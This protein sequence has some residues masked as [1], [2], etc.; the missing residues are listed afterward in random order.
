[1]SNTG[2]ID[3][4][5]FQPIDYDALA[6]LS[7]E[8][9]AQANEVLAN[10]N[11]SSS[12]QASSKVSSP[13]PSSSNSSSNSQPAPA[14]NNSSSS[15]SQSNSNTGNSAMANE[16]YQFAEKVDGGYNVQVPDYSRPAGHGTYQTSTKFIP[17]D[18][19]TVDNTRNTPLGQ[20]ATSTTY[21]ISVGDNTPKA[22]TGVGTGSTYIDPEGPTGQAIIGASE[23][24]YPGTAETERLQ[25]LISSA[26]EENNNNNDDKINANE[27]DAVAEQDAEQQSSAIDFSASEEYITLTNRIDE[28]EKQLAAQDVGTSSTSKNTKSRARG[29]GGLIGSVINKNSV[30]VDSGKLKIGGQVYGPDGSIYPS[31]TDAIQAGVYNFTYF[32]IST[33]VKQENR[34]LTRRFANAPTQTN[35]QTPTLLGAGLQSG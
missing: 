29:D 2:F 6:K 19:V 3:W 17:D 30:L 26:T 34:P 28:L 13:S 18:Q 16:S 4:N 20:G 31:V 15:N 8:D 25:G 23:I 10:T 14:S 24:S 33:G 27:S 21:D 12:N 5:N 35:T 11:T 32:P 22:D 1:M 7:K 9:I